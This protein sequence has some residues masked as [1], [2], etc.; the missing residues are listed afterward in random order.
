MSKLNEVQ[1]EF[2]EMCQASGL[3]SPTPEFKFHEDRKWRIDYFFEGKVK[4]ALEVEGGL[5]VKSRHRGSTGFLKDMEKYNELTKKEI[6]LYRVI[7]SKLSDSKT[8]SDL[9]KILL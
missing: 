9:Q 6:Y 3:P 8:F 1:L 4:I 5:W 7:P 2:I